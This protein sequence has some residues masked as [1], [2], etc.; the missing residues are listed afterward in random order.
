[1]SREY[2]GAAGVALA[3]G[4]ALFSANATG[5]SCALDAD[6]K[7]QLA[8]M[9]LSQRA[10]ETGWLIGG[11]AASGEGGW[12]G[13]WFVRGG[14]SGFGGG[15]ELVV[16]VSWIGGLSE[17]ARGAWVGGGSGGWVGALVAKGWA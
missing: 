9:E 5:N 2:S 12:I 7:A 10:R 14:G 4:V 15:R 13:G 16:G 6:V 17:R 1:M 11:R 3:S 8:R